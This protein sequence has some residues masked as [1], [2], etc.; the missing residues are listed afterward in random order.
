MIVIEKRISDLKSVQSVIL[1]IYGDL[2]EQNNQRSNEV[3]ATD[4]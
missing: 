3:L 1:N 4:A 2:N